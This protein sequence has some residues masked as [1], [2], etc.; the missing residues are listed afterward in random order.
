[1]QMEIPEE[2]KRLFEDFITHVSDGKSRV[3]YFS[4]MMQVMQG[5]LLKV[6]AV[7]TNKK[8][9]EASNAALDAVCD[10]RGMFDGEYDPKGY[11]ECYKQEMKRARVSEVHMIA[12]FEQL[13]CD[14][15]KDQVQ[16]I[17]RTYA[18]NWDGFA[19][20]IL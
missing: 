6:E 4:N 14:D 13:V 12:Q 2:I 5:S 11:L 8:M 18:D 19:K 9:K 17:A 20:A 16:V 7:K 1:M 15:I 3:L 10:E